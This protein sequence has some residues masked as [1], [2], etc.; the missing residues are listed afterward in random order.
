MSNCRSLL[1]VLAVFWAFATPAEGPPPVFAPDGMVVSDSVYASEAGVEMLRLG[2]NAFDAAAAT[3]FAMTV[4]Y[5][6]AGPLGGGGFMVAWT[7]EGEAISLDFRE[8]A[9]AGAHRDMF[10]DE[11]GEVIPGASLETAQASGVPG[12][13]DGLLRI[14]EERGSGRISREQLLAPAIRLA[15]EGFE[16]NWVQASRLNDYRE[17]FAAHPATSAVLIR[18]DGRAWKAGDRLVQRDLAEV[19]RRVAQRGRDGFYA[20]ETAHAIAE[21]MEQSGGLIGL[22][23]LEGYRSKW[24][25]PVSGTFHGY[26]VLSMGPPSSGGFLIIQMLNMLEPHNLAELGRGSSAYFHL[27][28]EAERRAYADRALHLGDPDHWDVPLAGLLSKDY[29]LARAANIDP[30]RAT[31]SAAVAAGDPAEYEISETG[32][33]SVADAQGNAV[34][35]T[36]TI[37]AAYGSGHVVPGTGILLNNEMDD[38]SAKPG[39]PNLYGVVGGE[40]NAIAPGKRMLSSMSPTIVVEDGR[41]RFVLG[42]PGG[43]SIPTTVLQVFLNAAVFDLDISDAVAAPRAH[44]QWKPDAIMVERGAPA[45]D[46]V[47]G[48]RRR[49]HTVVPYP[50]GETIGQANCI[51]IRGD[52]FYGAPDPRSDNAA[53]GL[54]IDR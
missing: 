30:D 6:L 27:L 35:V 23:D 47:D 37:N 1:A 8:T 39:V 32:H 9:P 21:Y 46:V 12:S 16:L 44:S 2:G 20:G 24:R 48:L 26:R 51:E 17:K 18:A 10:L 19:L 43:S 29:A 34:A 7:A 52:G 31:K 36:V 13:A 49:G 45:A 25:V 15:A 22:E 5:P 42:S 28:T 54:T 33:F 14:W 4:A 3:G 41:P 40:A 38:F 50:G 11:Q 53:A